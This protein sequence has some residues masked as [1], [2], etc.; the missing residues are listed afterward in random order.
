MTSNTMVAGLRSFL[1]AADPPDEAAVAELTRD[2]SGTEVIEALRSLIPESREVHRR[3]GLSKNISAATLADVERKHQLYGAETIPAWLV[4]IL[5]GDVIQVGRLQVERRPTLHGHALHIPEGGPL[6]PAQVDDALEQARLATNSTSFSCTSW[7]LDRG[8]A[9]ALPSSNIVQFARRFRIILNDNEHEDGDAAAA[10]FVFRQ[11]PGELRET[12]IAPSTR[13]EHVVL[14]R[15]LFGPRW[16]QPTGILELT[17]Q[18]SP[19]SAA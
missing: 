10:K 11:S 5:R 6:T 17:P 7:L 1:F 3:L 14:R 13:L 12:D 19:R 4:G 2:A 9:A 18:I 15:L 16:T 8:L